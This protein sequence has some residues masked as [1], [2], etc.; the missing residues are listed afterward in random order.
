M[1]N[2][3]GP[4]NKLKK[5]WKFLQEDSWESLV[6]FFVVA[7]IVIKFIFFPLLAVI[8]GTQLPLV[9]VESCSMYHDEKGMDNIIQK[10]FYMQNKITYDQT[11]SWDFKDGL[12]KGDVVFAVGTSNI[13]KGDVI[14]F[15][16]GTNHP[17]IH[18][19]INE[20]EPFSTYGDN[21]PGQLTIEKQISQ[22]Q[23]IGKAVFKIPYIGW[24]KLIFFEGSREPSQRG[25]C[26]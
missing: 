13:E 7:I 21:N 17:I 20:N 2:K 3:T 16:G 9:I 24:I 26:S 18:R 4:I 22:N 1:N 11:R 10:N 15:N 12:N 8:T 6:A 14:I 5:F 23:L 25:L 19:L